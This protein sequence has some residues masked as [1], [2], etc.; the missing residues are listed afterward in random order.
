MVRKQ[1]R[2]RGQALRFIGVSPAIIR[3]FRLNRFEFLLSDEVL[4]WKT[5]DEQPS[6]LGQTV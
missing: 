2:K 1:L 6:A 3:A 5:S 4:A